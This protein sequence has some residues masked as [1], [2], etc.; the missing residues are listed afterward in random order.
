MIK[1]LLKYTYKYFIFYIIGFYLLNFKMFYELSF[2]MIFIIP[3]NFFIIKYGILKEINKD[4]Y[5][6]KYYILGSLMGV[7]SL[8]ILLLLL[9]NKINIFVI[10]F[11]IIINGLEL[12]YL[13]APE[14]T[15]KN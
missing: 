8:F 12:L 13:D 1:Q 9:I 5:I 4:H 11:T 7:T 6:T 3:L 10:L 15:K 14:K 2:K